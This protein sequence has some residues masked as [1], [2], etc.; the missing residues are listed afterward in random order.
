[1]KAV[2]VKSLQTQAH[3]QT[4]MMFW[5]LFGSSRGSVTRR[6]IVNQLKVQPSNN[7]QLAKDLQMDYKSIKHHLEALEKNSLIGKFEAT[8]G[9]VYF[10]LPLFE[11]NNDMFL[12]IEEKIESASQFRSTK[13]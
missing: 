7:H 10:L 3:P 5:F 8:Y 6:K 13:R 9:A 11:E 2:T 1:M 12:E 4:K